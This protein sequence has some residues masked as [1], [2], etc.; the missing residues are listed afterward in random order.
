MKT[1]KIIIPICLV[2]FILNANDSADGSFIFNKEPKQELQEP[3][4]QENNVIYVKNITG[5]GESLE[6]A[7]NDAIQ[8]AMKFGVGEYLITKEE[9][10]NDELNLEV[11]N[12]SNAY[13]LDYRQIKETNENG[14]YKVSADV[15]LEKNKILG[16]LT[17]LNINHMDFS[18]GVLKNYAADTAEKK[19]NAKKMIEN[20]IIKPLENGLAYDKEIIDIQPLN[21]SDLIHARNE[22]GSKFIDTYAYEDAIDIIDELYVAKVRIKTN[23]NYIKKA[24]KIISLFSKKLSKEDNDKEA[25]FIV[26]NRKYFIIDK[27]IRE[28]V[29]IKKLKN[30]GI[31]GIIF[32]VIDANDETYI[33]KCAPSKIIGMMCAS[34]YTCYKPH[35]NYKREFITKKLYFFFN[36][37]KIRKFTEDDKKNN[38]KYYY[39]FDHNPS[40]I[41]SNNN[42][43]NFSKTISP[44]NQDPYESKYLNFKTKEQVFYIIIQLDKQ[45]TDNMQKLKLD[46]LYTEI[47][48][49]NKREE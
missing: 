2:C 36:L 13:I 35:E 46:F 45:D 21:R 19:E 34:T 43:L 18:S 20:E 11:A 27:Y 6:K 15:T 25:N 44:K 40:S 37:N 24:E 29:F 33:T 8:N 32:K 42:I 7:K 17:K 14:I 39:K 23:E 48:E 30:I 5:I 10:S 41:S 49:C 38:I 16:T 31:Y 28:E 4:I 26:D 12:Y 3:T 1:I 9:L 22:K 47:N